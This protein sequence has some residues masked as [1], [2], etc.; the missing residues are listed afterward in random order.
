MKHNPKLLYRLESKSADNGLW[1]DGDGS[2]V[3]GIGC[4]KGCKTKNLPMEY[5]KRYQ[6]DGRQWFS[7]CSNKEDLLHWYS[8]E[9]AKELIRNGFVFTKYLATEY[10]E[11]PLETVFIKSTALKRVEIDIEKLFEVARRG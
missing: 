11:Y 1:Y 9:D 6:K 5:D 2:F 7:S 10:T 3:W 8:I 4:I